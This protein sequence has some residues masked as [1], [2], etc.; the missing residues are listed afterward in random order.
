[1]ERSH[2]LRALRAA[3]VHGRERGPHAGP[4]LA[5]TPGRGGDARAARRVPLPAARGAGARGVVAARALRGRAGRPD[6]VRRRRRAVPPRRAPR[7]PRPP[8]APAVATATRP[9]GTRPRSALPPRPC[10]AGGLRAAASLP[11]RPPGNSPGARSG[12]GGG[13]RGGGREPL[14]V[15]PAD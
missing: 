3:P 14:H 5:G 8:A 13:R 7:P 6:A 4:G 15:D 11:P 9:G 1:A 10:T 2:A 12:R